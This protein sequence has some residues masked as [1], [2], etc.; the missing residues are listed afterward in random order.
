MKAESF[1]PS[2]LF[3]GKFDENLPLLEEFVLNYFRNKEKNKSWIKFQY[4]PSEFPDVVKYKENRYDLNIWCIKGD[5]KPT[6]LLKDLISKA[7]FIL[8][9]FNFS[10]KET[11]D[12]LNDG[13]GPIFQRVKLPIDNIQDPIIIGT[14]GEYINNNEIKSKIDDTMKKYNI[15]FFYEFNTLQ[16]NSI[17]PMVQHIENRL[18]NILLL[19]QNASINKNI[20][21]NDDDSDDGNKKKKLKWKK[22]FYSNLKITLII[23]YF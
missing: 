13:W 5:V 6:L 2:I 12:F 19:R 4:N 18:K 7:T 17:I 16:K 8:F 15:N 10:N 11:L 20:Q 14:K 23:N 9:V 1:I 3:I 22:R 21:A